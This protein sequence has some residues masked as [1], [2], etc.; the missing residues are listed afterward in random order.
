MAIVDKFIQS[1]IDES[2]FCGMESDTARAAAVDVAALRSQVADLL[3][4]LEPIKILNDLVEDVGI[5]DCIDAWSHKSKARFEFEAMLRRAS[6][7]Y[8]KVKG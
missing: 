2:E 3:A 1:A 8:R 7:T 6:E 5:N 4:A